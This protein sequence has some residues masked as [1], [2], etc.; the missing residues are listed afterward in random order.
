M[1]NKNP[2]SYSSISLTNDE[3]NYAQIEKELLAIV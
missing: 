1:Q 2:I 3:K